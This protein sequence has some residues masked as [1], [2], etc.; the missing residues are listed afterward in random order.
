V[1]N[2]KIEMSLRLPWWRKV[3]QADIRKSSRDIFERFGEEIIA[4]IVSASHAPRA[5]DLI[6]M[7]TDEQMIKEAA[8]WLT[9]RGDEKVLHEQR[10]EFVEWAILV[11]VIVGVLLDLLL[12][13]HGRIQVANA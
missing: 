8:A 9:E 6:A 7:Y 10:I 3:R 13:F 12:L 2:E 1:P 4:D 11:F 5:P